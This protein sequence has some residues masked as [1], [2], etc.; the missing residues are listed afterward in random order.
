VD[1]W[2]VPP[3]PRARAGRFRPGL[4]G[5]KPGDRSEA[6]LEGNHRDPGCFTGSAPALRAGRAPRGFAQPSELC[7]CLFGAEEVDGYPVITMELMPGGTLHDLLRQRGRLP[8]KE[9]V[10]FILD[11]IEGLEA[12]NNAGILHRDVKPSN[13][14]LDENGKAKIGDFGLSKTLERDSNVTISGAF[15]G[16]PS[17]ASPEQVRGREIVFR[18]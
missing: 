16:T 8:A 3:D 12:A 18:S 17:Y 5:R 11:V 1:V 15:I 7:L 2:V 9:A 4:G 10:D 13:C 6:G 14:F